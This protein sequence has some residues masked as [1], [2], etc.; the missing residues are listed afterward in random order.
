[1]SD[2]AGEVTQL[3]RAWQNGDASAL[4]ALVP[5]IYREL[6]NLAV[7]QM[8]GEKPGH[9]LSPTA[10]LHESFL[11]LVQSE[12]NPTWQ[13][14]K[15]F[16]VV[17]SKAMRQLLID[18]ARRKRAGKRNPDNAALVGSEIQHPSPWNVLDLDRALNRLA[19]Q[20]P[21]RA[22]ML[23]LRYFGGLDMDEIGEVLDLSKSTVS[24][25]L[26]VT[27]AWLSREIKGQ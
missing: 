25:E 26:R 7:W 20:E 3:L 10:L 9:T 23:E 8:N 16:Y 13:D 18:Y 21:R 22:K 24:R 1:M 19:E 12:A 14:R 2:E 15:H 11:K 6:H 4:D 17:A 27:T 5:L